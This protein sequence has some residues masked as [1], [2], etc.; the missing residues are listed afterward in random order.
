LGKDDAGRQRFTTREMLGLE[1]G[2]LA[3]AE[4]LAGR[5]GH[6]VAGHRQ[7]SVLSQNR[8]S[9]EQRQ[10]FEHV[11]GAGDLKALVGWRG[12]VRAPRFR[13]CARPG[14]RKVWR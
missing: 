6:G 14:R 13:R 10:A 8:L 7:R 1:R 5:E 9:D 11:T 4:A 2:L 12:R 3:D